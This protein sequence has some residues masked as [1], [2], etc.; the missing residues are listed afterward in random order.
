MN[1]QCV[2]ILN[3]DHSNANSQQHLMLSLIPLLKVT[4][5]YSHENGA[6]VESRRSNFAA[7]LLNPKQKIET[8]GKEIYFHFIMR[9]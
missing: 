1:V 5:S 9:T 8:L 6:C 3:S 7:A 2:Y 4:T